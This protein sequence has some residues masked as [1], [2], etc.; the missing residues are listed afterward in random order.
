MEDKIEN[1]ELQYLTMSDYQELKHT[2]IQAYSNMP[3]SY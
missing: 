1:V 3:G 2:M